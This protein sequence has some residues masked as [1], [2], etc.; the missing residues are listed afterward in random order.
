[1]TKFKEWIKAAGIRALR[2]FAQALLASIGCA[3]VISEV[4]WLYCL[5]AALLSA[6]LSILMSISGLPELKNE[7]E[8]VG[9]DEE[10]GR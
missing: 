4:D 7:D 1:M 8:D 5:S 6:I 3:V 9:N 2:T 10:D